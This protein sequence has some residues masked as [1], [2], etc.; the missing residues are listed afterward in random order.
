MIGPI[1]ILVVDDH[2]VLRDG[3]VAIL[4]TQ[5]AFEVVGEAETGQEAVLLAA[6]VKPDIVMMDLAMPG[7]DGVEAL[8]QNSFLACIA[9]HRR[10]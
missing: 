2:P 10:R 7:M 3:L 9:S 8:K 5:A 4:S 1:R 6:K